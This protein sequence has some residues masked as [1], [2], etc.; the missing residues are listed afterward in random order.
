[1][2]P[3]DLTFSS[4]KITILK[5]P[6]SGKLLQSMQW[7]ST[8]AH[9]SDRFDTLFNSYFEAIAMT[10]LKQPHY[11]KTIKENLSPIPKTFN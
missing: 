7:A 5:L 3:E 4:L 1:M 10:L 11:R 6:K 8:L 2:V 9:T